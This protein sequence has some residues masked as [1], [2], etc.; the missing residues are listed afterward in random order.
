M[1]SSPLLALDLPR[2]QG[3]RCSPVKPLDE[4]TALAGTLIS[5]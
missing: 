4:T 1:G 5:A 3:R 2:E